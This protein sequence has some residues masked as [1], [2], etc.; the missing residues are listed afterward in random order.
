MKL[1]KHLCLNQNCRNGKNTIRP[2]VEQQQ[3]KCGYCR[4]PLDFP[5][6]LREEAIPLSHQRS[7]PMQRSF[8]M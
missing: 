5:V 4:M 8:C 1:P 7:A 6:A 3:G 2:L